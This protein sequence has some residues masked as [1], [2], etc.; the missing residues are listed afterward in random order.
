MN[1][2]KALQL[3]RQ[4]IDQEFPT[5]P[6]Y[7]PRGI[8]LAIFDGQEVGYLNHPAPPSERPA[9]LVAATAVEIN[10][11]LTATIPTWVCAQPESVGPL[12]Y[13]ECFHVYQDRGGF[14]PDDLPAGFDFYR[15]LADYPELDPLYRA[16]CRA[17]A[18]THN[19]PFLP[20]TEKAA[21]L[22]ALAA[23]RYAILENLPGALALEQSSER[24]EGPAFY[25]Q[26]EADRQLNGS[27]IPPVPPACGYARQ[28]AV[29]AAVCR[30]LS[31]LGADW[32]LPIQA[33]QS[34]TQALIARFGQGQ[35]DLSEVQLGKKVHEE[36]AVV[37][38]VLESIDAEF[39][40][41]TIRLQV[42]AQ[43]ELRGFN[44]MTV[45]SAGSGRLL[46]Q[47]VYFLRL[48][49]GDLTLKAGKVLEDY[50]SNEILLPAAGVAFSQGCL[51]CHSEALEMMLSGIE[52]VGP[53]IYRTPEAL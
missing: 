17:E 46:H 42:P 40:A 6:D 2:T 41:D 22:G 26:Q 4:A 45:L 21:R 38:A 24:R 37:A 11:H 43:V 20:P 48:P 5:W 49:Q 12:A 9:N 32:H 34:P 15:T 25:V 10:G 19:H 7:S 16:L 30:L 44:P 18:D 1:V 52:E 51:S 29:G 3:A 27:E 23:R 14:Q 31:Q 36:H 35:P 8:P 39:G 33:G 28:Y 53:G 47:D 50:R 13:H